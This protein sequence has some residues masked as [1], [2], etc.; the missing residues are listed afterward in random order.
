MD[1]FALSFVILKSKLF[2]NL[3]VFTFYFVFFVISVSVLFGVIFKDMFL[4]FL[5]AFFLTVVPYFSSLTL[6]PFSFLKGIAD[7]Q[8]G[9]SPFSIHYST[10]G[11][12][13]PLA[14]VLV[15]G[16]IFTRRDVR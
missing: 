3:L 6:P 11:L 10:L 1:I 8:N 4:S 7:I 14:L 9:I 2:L 15:S 13:I 5:G 16:I 12:V